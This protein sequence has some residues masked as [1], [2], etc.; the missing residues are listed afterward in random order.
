MNGNSSFWG[1][2]RVGAERSG[3]WTLTIP[4]W[5]RGTWDRQSKQA[6]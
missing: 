3:V 4:R 5:S 2:I 6:A 1:V